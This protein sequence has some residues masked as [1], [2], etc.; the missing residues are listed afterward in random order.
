MSP[1]LVNVITVL[2]IIVAI[3][4]LFLLAYFHKQKGTKQSLLGVYFLLIAFIVAGIS[5]G[6]ATK[7]QPSAFREILMFNAI[8]VAVYFLVIYLTTK[9]NK[10]RVKSPLSTRKIAF[11]GILVGLASALMLLGFPIIPGFIFLKVELSGLI[12]LM[13]FLWFDF[14]TA[15]LVSLLTNFIHVFL[16]G[17]PPLIL[18]LDEGVNF[19]ATVVFLAPIAIFLKR[20]QLMEKKQTIRFLLIS[21]AG[22]LFTTIVMTLYNYFINLPLIYSWP[23]PFNQVVAVFGLFNLIKWGLVALVVNLTWRRL[24]SLKAIG[25]GQYCELE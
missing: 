4:S 3:A 22:V 19:I 6:L 23:M 13:A 5:F 14:R 2:S 9:I 24:Y 15:L 18:F 20:D 25:E 10:H 16:P 21:S 17:T 7:S 12:I 1:I 11:L 8:I